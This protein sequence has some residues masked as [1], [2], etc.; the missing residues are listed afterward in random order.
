MKT[1]KILH[2]IQG[3]YRGGSG[4]AL[5]AAAKY[6]SQLGS[7]QHRL[8]ALAPTSP[9]AIAMAKEA[10]LS[11]ANATDGETVL[12]EIENA[13]IVHLHFWNNPQ[14]YEFLRSEL[15]AMRLLI[16]FHVAG[17][18]PPQI[19]T[20]ELVDFSDFALACSPYTYEHPVFQNLP[21]EVRLKKTGMVY[22]AADF[23]RVSDIQPRHHDTFN[24]GYIGHISFA[25]MHQNYVPMSGQIDIPNV[26][27]IVCGGGRQ[28][29][30][31][32][33]AQQLGVAERFDFRGH[34]EDINSVIEILDVY[35]YPLC[36]DTYA[37]S[38]L[39]LQEVMYAEIPPVV[40]PYGGVKRLVINNYTGLIVHSELEYKQAIEYL[41]HHPEER[42]RL[43]RN[44]KEYAQQIFGAENAAKQLNPIYERLI[45][46][47]KCRRE[48][49]IDA[50]L[51]LLYQPVSLQDLT[52]QPEELS[53]AKLFAKSLG[54]TAHEFTVSLTSQNIQELFEAERKIAASSIL[55]SM[56]EGGILQYLDSYQNDGYLRL[57][58]G[59]VR[60]HQGRNAE[61]V[62]E[63]TTAIN[64]G[65]NHWRVAWYLAQVAAIVNDIPLAEKA[66]R[67]VLQAVP[68]LVEAQEMLQRLESLSE[69]SVDLSHLSLRDI[70]LIIFPDW[71]LS[72]DALFQELTDVIRAI[73]THPDQSHMTLLVDTSNIPDEDAELAISG[74]VM[75]LLMEE[76]LDVTSGAEISLIGKLSQS[77]WEALL[78]HLQARIVLENENKQAIALLKVETIPSFELDR[79][80]SERFKQRI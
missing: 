56:G 37:A 66:L 14:M 40:F 70:N 73:A 41:Y 27:F 62:S 6:S 80:S 74:V 67:V 43:S 33:Q 79:F 11:V 10:G 76:D 34:V 55:L 32:Q 31:Q 46:W 39:N 45:E 2:V 8:V 17:D 1:I 5:V 53:G 68:D 18:K 9:D 38:E 64:L 13:D 51:M 63:L 71:S 15:P 61:A 78:P 54:D 22:G 4:R 21:A 49:G 7:F 3:F 77:Q 57:W 24:V 65:C 47:P 16:W 29:Y 44:A 52:G 25:K 36:E 19:I 12:S 58:S 60:Q 48:W 28:E 26:R 42:R 20:K 50:D 69:Q 30:L 72:E 75:N 23:E 59:L 35:G